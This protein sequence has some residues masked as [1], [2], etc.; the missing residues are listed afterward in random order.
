MGGGG[1]FENLGAETGVRGERE[2]E[3]ELLLSKME[4]YLQTDLVCE[5]E[6]GERGVLP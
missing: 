5:S 2:R 4:K 1:W 3:R 6:T